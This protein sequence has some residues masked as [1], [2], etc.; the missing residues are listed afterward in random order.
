L[1]TGQIDV[2]KP[3]RNYRLSNIKLIA[4]YAGDDEMLLSR[5]W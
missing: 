5:K 1:L 2:E 3:D 4:P